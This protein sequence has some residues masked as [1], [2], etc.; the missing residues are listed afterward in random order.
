MAQWFY[1]LSSIETKFCNK[2]LMIWAIVN[3]M[4]YFCWFYRISPCSAAKNVI[5]LISVLTIW[6]CPSVDHLLGYWE[7]AFAMTGMWSWEN[8]VSLWTTSF[9]T[10][11]ANFPVT[12]GISW[13]PTFAF[14]SPIMKRISFLVLILE[15]V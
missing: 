2:E 1:L 6:W 12:L 15:G 3:S 10:P 4:S 8:S 5:N 11:K 13:L 9:C 14:Q 7:K